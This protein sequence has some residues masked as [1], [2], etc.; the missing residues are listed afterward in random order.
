M[1][2]IN[3]QTWDH[4]WEKGL[5]LSKE[6]Q[7]HTSTRKPLY[8]L[9]N[10]SVGILSKNEDLKILEIGCGTAIDSCIFASNTKRSKF[11]CL[12]FFY[13][14]LELANKI[15]KKFNVKLHFLNSDAGNISIKDKTFDLIFS[16]GVMEHFRDPSF[17]MKEQVRLLKD[18]GILVIDV[19]QAYTLC[20]IIKHIKIKKGTWPY[21]WETQFSYRG[22][23]SLGA[24]YGLEAIAVCGHE[25]DSHVRF[26]N[27]A[28]FRNIIRRLQKVNPLREYSIFKK[29]ES[30][31]DRFWNMLE[32]KWGHYFLI[33]IA[34]AFKKKKSFADNTKVCIISPSFPNMKCGLADYVVNLI[35]FL[36]LQGKNLD[37]SLVTSNNLRVKEYADSRSDCK[38]KIYPAVSHWNLRALFP[39]NR[40]INK[41]NPDVVHIMYHWNGYN[42]GLLKGMMVSL[43]PMFIKFFGK[44]RRIIVISFVHDLM[45][46]YLF[47]KA[48]LLRRLGLFIMVLFSDKLTVHAEGYKNDL[49]RLFPFLRGR[50]HFIPCG[51]GIFCEQ[52]AKINNISDRSLLDEATISF[53]GHIYPSKGLE[54]LIEAMKILAD[55]NYRLKLMLIG[56]LTL[57]YGSSS[58][59][60]YPNKIKK[61]ISASGL[62]DAVTWLGFCKPEDV[63]IYLLKSNICVLPFIEGVNERGS[64]FSTVFSHG[65]PLVTTKGPYTPDKLKN[66]ENIMLVPAGDSQKLAQAIE[67]LICD[68]EL[69]R[70]ISQAGK[71]LYDKEYSW[72]VI[73]DKTMGLYS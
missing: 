39:V 24:K 37:I 35:K 23:A 34:V 64:S 68:T 61:L 18:E 21:G 29:I 14:A 49:V 40:L 36:S 73:A 62:N 6:I 41:I 46:P 26:F 9:L 19:P 12:D 50:V 13:S 56:G 51:S 63:S 52:V 27:L 30:G 25:Y 32:K 28:L 43:L 53:F 57:D 2:K 58:F 45:G 59:D 17:M 5:D 47:P 33:N 38:L 22:L 10:D 3:Q 7:Y 8:E 11:F 20:T 31:Y 16:Q 71:E 67:E 4:L 42:E 65:L 72:F 54:Y 69:R 55:K 66:H 60:A 70:R 44:K 15:S 1:N 48:G